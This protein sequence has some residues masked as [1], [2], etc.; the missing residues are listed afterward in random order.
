MQLPKKDLFFYTDRESLTTYVYY[1]NKVDQNFK[2]AIYYPDQYETM[3][4]SQIEAYRRQV[5]FKFIKW[6]FFNKDKILESADRRII[7]S[8]LVD[9]NFGLLGCACVGLIF[10]KFLKRIEA[11]FLEIYLE[12]KIIGLNSLRLIA[13]SGISLYG[14]NYIYKNIFGQKY[15]QDLSL[16]YKE[17]FLPNQIVDSKVE[18]IIQKYFPFQKDQQTTQN[19]IE[20]Q[21]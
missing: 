1:K 18:G 9:F 21:K 7:T 12:D 6:S 2:K 19:V 17:Q 4:N 3:T 13:S 16:E 8:Q 10:F 14:L 20:Q 5:N 15:L 11:P